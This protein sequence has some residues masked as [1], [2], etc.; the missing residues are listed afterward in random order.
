MS[1]IE[2][3]LRKELCD[4]E[5]SEGYSESFLNT[6]IATQIKV[7]R[8]QRKMTQTD[9]AGL[10]GTTQAGVSRYENVNYSSWNVKTLTKLAR[11]FGVWLKV[12]FEPFGD[13]PKE[14]IQFS[15]QSLERVKREDDPGLSAMSI[16][17]TPMYY[18]E[19]PN[20][21]AID[22]RKKPPAYGDIGQRN[23]PSWNEDSLGGQSDSVPKRIPVE[24]EQ[25]DNG[26]EEESYASAISR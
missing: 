23:V 26:K 25:S 16:H 8:E 4:A 3:A 1:D 22:S 20:V 2:V 12:S 19:G 21:I 15:R 14:V 5:Y 17:M 13:L 6:Y 18:E 9:L 24:S 7:I 11:A 10:I